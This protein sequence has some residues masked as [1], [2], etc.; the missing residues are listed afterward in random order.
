MKRRMKEQMLAVWV[1]IDGEGRLMKTGDRLQAYYA[2][3]DDPVEMEDVGDA[4]RETKDYAQY[5]GPKPDVSASCPCPFSI[6][7]PV[8]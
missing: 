8:S 2:E 3:E 4:Q 1:S 7:I 5:S 6:T